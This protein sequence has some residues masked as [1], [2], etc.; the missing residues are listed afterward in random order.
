M[1]RF[2]AAASALALLATGPALRADT[3]H[4]HGA[5]RLDVVLDGGSLR[6][7]MQ[8]PLDNL[9]GFEHAP[10][11]EHQRAALAGMETALRDAQRLFRPDAEARCRAR[12][13]EIEHPYASGATPA[14]G[15]QAGHAEARA[16]WTFDCERPQ[17]LRR[18]EVLLFDAFRGLKRIRVQSATPRGQGSATLTP[19]RRNVSL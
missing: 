6:I 8:S 5:A 18:L 3:A 4:Q 16:R 7:E 9:V 2:L 11:N 14:T 19:S 13:T 1:R 12:G 15:L 17:S 10:R